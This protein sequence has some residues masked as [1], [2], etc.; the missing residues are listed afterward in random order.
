M[1]LSIL[2]GVS[3]L[4]ILSAGG[5]L[6]HRIVHSPSE[7]VAVDRGGEEEGAIAEQQAPFLDDLVLG[8]DDGKEML[9]IEDNEHFADLG[10]RQ[11]EPVEDFGREDEPLS[12]ERPKPS[13]GKRK[14]K[15]RAPVIE[16]D[17]E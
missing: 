14:G 4:I 1:I 10:L 15:G 7:E 6:Y 12:E 11:S 2:G 5:W 8:S 3:G 17:N 9:L 16:D 13:R